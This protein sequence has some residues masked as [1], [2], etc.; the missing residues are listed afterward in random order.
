LNLESKFYKLPRKVNRTENQHLSSTREH[1]NSKFEKEL[2][3]YKEEKEGKLSKEERELEE[4]L[5]TI[6]KEII[7]KDREREPQEQDILE[8]SWQVT[9]IFTGDGMD[10][11]TGLF[12]TNGIRFVPVE[13]K[14]NYPT[15]N[16]PHI[17]LSTDKSEDL[18]N[19]EK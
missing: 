13:G 2:R 1:S 15:E 8:S 10:N 5:R 9:T 17:S 11:R 6:K 16:L 3:K 7:R 18:L 14:S 12:T 4:R 19:E